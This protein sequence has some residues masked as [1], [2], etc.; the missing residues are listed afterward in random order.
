M[1]LVVDAVLTAMA[2][3]IVTRTIVAWAIA[4]RATDVIVLGRAGHG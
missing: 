4:A 3:V 1:A 2:R